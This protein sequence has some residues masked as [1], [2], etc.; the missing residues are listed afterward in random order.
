MTRS[1]RLRLFQL[2]RQWFV[3]G[4]RYL[5]MVESYAEGVQLLETL[6]AEAGQPSMLTETQPS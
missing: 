3:A 5:R 4:G 2:D 1:S 6:R